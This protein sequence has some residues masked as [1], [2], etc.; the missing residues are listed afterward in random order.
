MLGSK[1]SIKGAVKAALLFYQGECMWLS[2]S[3]IHNLQLYV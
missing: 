2:I 1:R 3:K